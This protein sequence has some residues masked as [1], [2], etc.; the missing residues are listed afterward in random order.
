MPARRIRFKAGKNIMSQDPKP[1]RDTPHI[2]YPIGSVSLNPEPV[3]MNH[4]KAL[5]SMLLVPC[6]GSSVL[7]MLNT[8][9][10]ESLRGSHRIC[11]LNIVMAPPALL[12]HE[13]MQQLLLPLHHYLMVG[14]VKSS[15]QYV[16]IATSV[17]AHTSCKKKQEG[18]VQ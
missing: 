16:C 12:K 14:P 6:K 13:L 3:E 7:I 10:T 1:S 17:C 9:S 2:L 11:H 15:L 18:S 8:S 4:A 5:R